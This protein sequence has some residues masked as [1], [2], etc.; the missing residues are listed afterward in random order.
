MTFDQIASTPDPT[1]TGPTLYANAASAR[2]AYLAHADRVRG[3]T[4]ESPLTV[5]ERRALQDDRY[6]RIL[7]RWLPRAL[8]GSESATVLCLRAMDGQQNLHGLKTRPGA[9]ETDTGPEDVGDEL[10]ER[11]EQSR[12]EARAAALRSTAA[13][14]S[15]PPPRA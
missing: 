13:V 8:D 11:R 1:N 2:Q 14:T 3:T 15:P 4:D 10:A 9:P 5:R 12:Q 6:E 7:Q